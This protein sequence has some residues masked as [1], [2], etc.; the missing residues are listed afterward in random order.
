M[1]GKICKAITLFYD[2]KSHQMKTKS[3]PAL[4]LAQA[5]CE[6]YVVIPISKISRSENINLEY[7]I[8]IDPQ[9]YPKTNLKQLSYARTH[10]QTIIH[11]SQLIDPFCD[12]KREYNDLYNKI[13]T[14]RTTFSNEINRQATE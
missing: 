2:I 4:V 8:K 7:D 13:L 11:S 6:D 9:V 3:R 5:D 10:K 1:I 14:Q 12:L